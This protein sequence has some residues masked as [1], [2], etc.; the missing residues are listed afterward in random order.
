MVAYFVI[1]DDTAGAIL[2]I[3]VGV[4]ILLIAVAYAFGGGSS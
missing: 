4:A 2:Q 1:G 3:I